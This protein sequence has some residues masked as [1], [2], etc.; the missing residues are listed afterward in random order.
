[1]ITNLDFSKYK[2]FLSFG[3]S[4]TD[5][6]WMTWADIISEEISESYKYAQAGAGNF[7]IFQSFNEAL[8]HHKICK[9]D[10]VMIMFSNV[11]REDRFTKNRGWITP[12]NLYYQDEYDK[13]F[14]DKFLCHHG[15]LMRDLN[16]ANSLKTMLDYIGC[17]YALMS[18]VPFQSLKSD[19]LLIENIEYLENFYKDILKEIL[20]SPFEIIFNF[21][22][23]SRKRRPQYHV[24]WKK[25]KYIDNHP[26]P[27]E[28]L[29][30][31]KLI[32]P[33]VRFSQNTLKKVQ[34]ETSRCLDRHFNFRDFKSYKKSCHPRLGIDSIYE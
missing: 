3:C 32:F 29:E 11:T 24:S 27:E 5:Y 8:I 14:I 31:L 16:I 25:E 34:E 1:M 20:P 21:D 17:D 13:N 28:H 30:Y 33:N 18:I 6:H 9:D 2:R 22:W 15:Y 26:T 12:G 7:Y 10:L 4:F 19:S 23:N